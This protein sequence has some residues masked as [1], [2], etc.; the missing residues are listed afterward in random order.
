MLFQ[1]SIIL[2]NPILSRH[3][4]TFGI[5]QFIVISIIAVIHVSGNY[6]QPYQ[7][8]IQHT[9]TRFVFRFR[10]GIRT[11]EIH[12]QLFIEGF[13]SLPSAKVMAHKCIGRHHSAGRGVSIREVTL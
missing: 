7:R 2:Y 6:I 10:I 3:G 8:I 13:K 1:R 5:K 9:A 12:S 11:R 4:R